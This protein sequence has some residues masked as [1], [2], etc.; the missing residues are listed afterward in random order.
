MKAKKTKKKISFVI[1]G[2]KNK[3]KQKIYKANS[4]ISDIT[5]DENEDEEIA[6]ITQKAAS[7]L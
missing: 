2:I 4:N 6:H 3:N 1:G 5:K 7:K